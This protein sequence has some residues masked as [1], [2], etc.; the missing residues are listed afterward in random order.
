MRLL[1]SVAKATV[2]LQ[3]GGKTVSTYHVS[4]VLTEQ[5]ASSAESLADTASSGR[6]SGRNVINRYCA[7]CGKVVPFTDSGKVRR[8]ANGKN[9]H[10]YAIYK[11]PK[12]HTWNKKIA[13]ESAAAVAE[14]ERECERESE[15]G[16]EHGHE[17][18][19]EN[20]CE[21]K[22]EFG[23]KYECG[24][25][26]DHEDVRIDADPPTAPQP[27]S[28][29]DLRV[30]GF[31]TIAIRILAAPA[32]MRLDHLLAQYLRE[33]SRSEWQRRIREGK[34]LVNQNIVKASFTLRESVEVLIA[35]N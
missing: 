4:W 23:R 31:S 5:Y 33:C 6:G 28:L 27:L 9:I 35:I 15:C 3:N 1:Y 13:E 24:C 7:N 14:R 8:N 19:Y 11:C 34:V 2:P 16:H 29:N 21:R 20:E 17:C 12:D 10:I 26:H 22:Y 18:E 30:A 25:R 32:E